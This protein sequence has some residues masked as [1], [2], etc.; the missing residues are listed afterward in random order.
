MPA[1]LPS[2]A[3]AVRKLLPAGRD[4]TVLEVHPVAP[5]LQTYLQR[6][7]PE[8]STDLIGIASRWA[9]FQRVAK[10]MLI[11]AG[12]APGEPAGS[13]CHAPGMEARSGRDVRGRV[14]RG[15]RRGI[16]NGCFSLVFR[17]F[18]EASIAKM[19][20]VESRVAGAAANPPVAV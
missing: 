8:H 13:R 3:A 5:E 2:K 6:Y 9:E 12:L 4:L 20:E 11:A 1:V 19:R 17:L 7:L 10:T 14:R 16:A 15:H 18:D